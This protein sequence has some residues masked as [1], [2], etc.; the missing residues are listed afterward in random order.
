M[1]EGK[2]VREGSPKEV[3]TNEILKKVYEVEVKVINH[4][5]ICLVFPAWLK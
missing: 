3:L 4:D 2:I 5:G 1:K